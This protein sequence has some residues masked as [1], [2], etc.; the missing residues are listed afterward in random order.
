MVVVCESGKNLPLPKAK[1]MPRGGRTILIR[2]GTGMPPLEPK[3]RMLLVEND[4]WLTATTNRDDPISVSKVL[5]FES[6]P[7]GSHCMYTQVYNYGPASHPQR[8]L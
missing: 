7:T 1:T 3:Y 4:L 2:V 6:R 5:Y 8:C